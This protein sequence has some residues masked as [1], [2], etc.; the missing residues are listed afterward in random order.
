MPDL[1]HLT[2]TGVP[3]SRREH[4][5]L[6][7]I[8]QGHTFSQ[9]F[10]I[11]GVSPQ[12]STV[13]RIK[14]KLGAH[15]MEHA[16]FL[17]VTL[18]LIGAQ[19]RCGTLDGYRDH[20]G[21]LGDRDPCRACRRAFTEYA[22]RQEAP[23]LKAVP[24]TEPELRM[25]RAFDS[26]RTF[27]Q[28]LANWGCSRRTLDDVR[29]NLYRKLDV[30][31]LPQQ[32]KQ[33]AALEAGRRLGYLRPAPLPAPELIEPVPVQPRP[34]TELEVKTLAVLAGGA[35]LREAGVELGIAGA[36]VSSKLARIYRKLGVLHHVHGERREAAVK[37]ARNQ[38]YPV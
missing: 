10:A 38:G 28:I 21:R 15:T 23:V 5:Y 25:L 34:L 33:T 12:P 16:V 36:A 37:E 11:I 29:I 19:P 9:A 27:K 14:G 24:L 22:E 8:S 18:D 30:A 1:P 32:S 13:T 26:G 31:H 7:L 4:E 17:A 3:L 35:S 20:Y 2:P 6:W